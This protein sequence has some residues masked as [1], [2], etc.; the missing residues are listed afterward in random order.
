MEVLTSSTG[1]GVVS[2]S[3]FS[4]TT[5]LVPPTLPR[6]VPQQMLMRERDEARCSSASVWART[7]P[8]CA[9]R[10]PVAATTRASPSETLVLWPQAPQRAAWC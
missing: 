8:P 7:T 9:A 2:R 3:L 4:A 1:S 5:A 10:A 6:C